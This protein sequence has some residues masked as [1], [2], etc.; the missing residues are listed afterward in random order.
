MSEAMQAYTKARAGLILDQPFFG[1]L[2]LRLTP[3][4][5]PDVPTACTDGKV[6]MFNPKWFLKLS[7]SCLINIIK[8]LSM[9]NL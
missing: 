5:N 6:I 4:E 7:S 1:T 9:I 8:I 3:I 2:S